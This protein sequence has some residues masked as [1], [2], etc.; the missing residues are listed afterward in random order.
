[1][2]NRKEKRLS[3]SFRS[4]AANLRTRYGIT[5]QIYDVL[6]AA[7]GGRCAICRRKRRPNEARF[8]VDHNHE[9]KRIRGILCHNCNVLLGHANE[10]ILILR[11]AIEYVNKD[12]H[13]R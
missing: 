11:N 2:G 1:M 4:I 5:L 3:K 9:T 6:L 12:E 10:N 8:Y 13:Q 7:Q